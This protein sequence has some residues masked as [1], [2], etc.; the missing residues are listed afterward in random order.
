MA[1]I[2]EG[3]RK[4][5]VFRMADFLPHFSLFQAVTLAMLFK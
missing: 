1:H 5:G 2:I 4:V 3:M